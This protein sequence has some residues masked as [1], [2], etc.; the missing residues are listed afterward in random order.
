MRDGWRPVDS[1]HEL[2]PA[3]WPHDLRCWL[4]DRL[5]VIST[6]FDGLVTFARPASAAPH[7]PRPDWEADQARLAG[8]PPP[9]A[10]R[11]WLLRSPWPEIGMAVVVSLLISRCTEL[12]RTGFEPD[13]VDVARE[14]LTWSFADVRHWWTGTDADTARAWLERGRSGEDVAD[15]VTWELGPTQL[16]QLDGIDESAAVR[17]CRSV[18]RSGNAAVQR[19]LIWRSLGLPADPPADLYRFH[20]WPA[21]QIASW[22][23]AGFDIPTMIALIETPLTNAIE[24]RARGYRTSEVVE[25][26]NADPLLT[27]KGGGRVHRAWNRRP[28][29]ARL[30]RIRLLGR[31]R[32]AIRQPWHSAERGPGVALEGTRTWRCRTGTGITA[33]LPTRWL[34]RR[35]RNL[36]ARHRTLRQRSARNPWS[37][38]RESTKP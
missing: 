28:G 16:D 27:A 34:G 1:S 7:D 25:L 32:C 23:Q 6:Y 17:W 9:P 14:M 13:Y 5:P 24:W 21:E 26:I 35:C 15:L 38:G 4:P 22:L 19:I 8:L 30:D 11:I 36:R 2:L 10:G 31:R 33:R 29:T 37:D 18:G 3:V 12:G 20:D